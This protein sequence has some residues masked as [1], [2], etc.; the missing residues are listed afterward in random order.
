[1]NDPQAIQNQEPAPH[2][3]APRR[4]PREDNDAA[5]D[6]DLDAAHG[7]VDAAEPRRRPRRQ[8]NRADLATPEARQPEPRQEELSL[9]QTRIRALIHDIVQAAVPGDLLCMKWRYPQGG[10]WIT[11]RGQVIAIMDERSLQVLWKGPQAEPFAVV[12]PPEESLRYASIDLTKPDPP[13]Q[14][15]AQHP[16]QP[17]PQWAEFFDYT[18]QGK[19]FTQV[20]PGLRI[21]A[22]IDQSDLI[23]YPN[24]WIDSADYWVELFK[25]RITE[26]AG[27]P[28]KLKLK[29]DLDLDIGLM[30]IV[31]STLT[32]DLPKHKLRPAFALMAR[33]LS[34]I[35]QYSPMYNLVPDDFIEQFE[36]L[37]TT[38][39]HVD[40]SSLFLTVKK[41]TTNEDSD[42]IKSL[43][44]EVE[45]LRKNSQDHAR[46]KDRDLTSVLRM[47][48]GQMA[49]SQTPTILTLPS[50]PHS[51][52]PSSVARHRSHSGS[53]HS[54]PSSGFR[55][56]KKRHRKY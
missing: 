32:K 3:V 54:Q 36:K 23:F 48:S 34:R 19:S 5:P 43:R 21:P 35:L 29:A 12:F 39:T 31:L 13:Q 14:T 55:Q 15:P 27:W 42:P 20:C 25:A 9:K 40:F 41:S 46:D 6:P 8:P 1:M 26:I 28:H 37:W 47:A 44:Q 56:H 33:I 16:N 53:G 2:D 4:R 22:H 30:E 50:A 18:T 49:R 52:T 17:Q 51:V 24:L 38:G 7:V 10:P 11:W 45:T